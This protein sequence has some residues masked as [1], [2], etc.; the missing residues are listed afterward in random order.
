MKYVLLGVLDAKHI[1]KGSK[2][3]V[4][5]KKKLHELGIKLDSVHY[6]QGVFDFV[7]VIDAPTA[8]AALSFSIWYAKQGYGRLVTLPAFDAKAMDKAV[9]RA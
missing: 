1:G 2:R 6:T 4:A 3:V 7:D 8:E 5:A 9:G